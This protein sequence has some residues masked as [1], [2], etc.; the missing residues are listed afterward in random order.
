MGPK[1]FGVLKSMVGSNCPVC[2][3]EEFEDIEYFVLYCRGYEAFRTQMEQ[4]EP[5]LNLFEVF[6]LLLGE[7]PEDS[8]DI[9]LSLLAEVCRYATKALRYRT[10][11]LETLR[12]A[13][14][15]QNQ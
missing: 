14:E 9:P 3:S 10:N 5:D 6:P 1:L 15:S 13:Y 8:V 4:Q 2:N 11:I 12:I 7:D